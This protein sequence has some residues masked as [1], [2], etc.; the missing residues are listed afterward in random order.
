MPCM[1]GV[2]STCR[3]VASTAFV[4]LVAIVHWPAPHHASFMVPQVQS[5]YVKPETGRLMLVLHVRLEGVSAG[6]ALG[7]R[8][9]AAAVLPLQLRP[10]LCP[11]PMPWCACPLRRCPPAGLLLAHP[12]RA[13]LEHMSPAGCG[14][15]GRGRAAG[16][17]GEKLD[18]PLAQHASLPACLSSHL[19]PCLPLTCL[20]ACL[21]AYLY[22]C[23]PAHPV[24][25]P[26]DRDVPC[27]RPSWPSMAFVSIATRWVQAR[28]LP[29]GE[30]VPASPTFA[31]QSVTE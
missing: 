25:T 1:Y 31:L 8:A 28:Q 16:A 2:R 19:P 30:H 6:A 23:P 29:I 13:H 10:T 11:P 22:A 9:A 5:T 26:T 7:Q 15:Q 27:C 20:L 21:P 12:R 24:A 18:H 14:A 17:A 3:Q 4:A